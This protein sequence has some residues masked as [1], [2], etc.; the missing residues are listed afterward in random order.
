[1]LVLFGYL[2]K[3]QW[4]C[5]FECVR[6]LTCIFEFNNLVCGR[7]YGVAIIRNDI[8]LLRTCV[9]KAS[10]WKLFCQLMKDLGYNKE[11]KYF[12]DYPWNFVNQDY[13]PEEI[14]NQ[15]LYIPQNNALEA[16][17]LV[18]ETILTSDENL[19]CR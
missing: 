12:R 3:V 10:F 7:L 19:C 1:M 17:V 11:Y 6:F 13:L 4:L 2:F 18:E 16:K 14:Q 15:C 5:R 8:G 9:L